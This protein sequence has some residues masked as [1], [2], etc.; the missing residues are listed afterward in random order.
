MD[1]I[2]K[3]E[4]LAIRLQVVIGV[5][6]V[7]AAFHK[8]ADPPDF[9]HMVYNYKMTPGSLI[10]LVAIYLPWVEMAAGAALILGLFGKR[11][12]A[13]LVGL[14]LLVF[15]GAISFNLMR[16]NLID[17][18]CFEGSGV[19]KTSSELCTEMYWVLARDILMLLGVAQI[20]IATRPPRKPLEAAQAAPAK[21]AAAR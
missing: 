3:S 5:V 1:R 9:A 14:M 13:A 11:G 16:G 2:F 12:G 15:I 19:T 8:I 21:A 6:F 7:Y 10:N 20:L 4:W 17:C 18:G